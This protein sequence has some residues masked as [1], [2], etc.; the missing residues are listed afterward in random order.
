VRYVDAL[1]IRCGALFLAQEGISENEGSAKEKRKACNDL[2][3]TREGERKR[4]VPRE[5]EQMH[6]C[7]ATGRYLCDN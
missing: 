5:R 1:H 7:R 3:E 2:K 6:A 4:R